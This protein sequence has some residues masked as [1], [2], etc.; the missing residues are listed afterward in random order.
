MESEEAKPSRT[1][2]HVEGPGMEVLDHLLQPLLLN[3]LRL[4]LPTPP[5][6]S[7]APAPCRTIGHRP[8]A[9]TL[10]ELDQ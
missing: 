7:H 8:V 3:L 5:P 10:G 4:L 1:L 6:L 9:V 2:L